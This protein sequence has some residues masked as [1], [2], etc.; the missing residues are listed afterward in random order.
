MNVQA[1]SKH[2]NAKNKPLVI[3][4]I[5]VLAAVYHFGRPTLERVLNIQLPALVGDNRHANQHGNQNHS[6]SASN[7]GFNG[8]SD[9]GEAGQSVRDWLTKVGDKRYESP[10][11]LLYTPSRNE[12]RIEHVLLHC[13]DNPSKP[14]HGIFTAKGVDVFKE[15]DE[16]YE[17]A[18][19]KSNRVKAESSRGKDTFT[20]S[21]N[22]KVGFDGGSKGKRNGG[23][24]L[25]KI[26]LVL[27][28]GNR[29]ITA[30]P[31]Y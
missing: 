1:K 9:Q 23:R 4:G 18:K 25:K 8:S 31:T 3:I 26:K 28:D 19:Q 11:G 7:S 30:F 6:P 27:V 22:R 29:V 16:A 13:R 20:V 17:L 21:M 5:L 24:E 14:A 2:R 12:H 10:A 15:I